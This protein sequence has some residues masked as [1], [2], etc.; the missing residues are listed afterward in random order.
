MGARRGGTG[1]SAD[2]LVLPGQVGAPPNEAP[3]GPPALSPISG[4]SPCLSELS[5]GLSRSLSRTLLSS[6]LVSLSLSLPLSPV[7]LTELLQF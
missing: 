7:A 3:V 2:H 1:D 5:S 6:P 4:Q